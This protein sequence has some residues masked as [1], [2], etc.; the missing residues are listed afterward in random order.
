M[1]DSWGEEGAG[2]LLAIY[3]HFRSSA[4]SEERVAP[5]LYVPSEARSSSIQ[6]VPEQVYCALL[7]LSLAFRRS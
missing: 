2:G 5:G 3:I 7:C 6:E 1:P 4:L